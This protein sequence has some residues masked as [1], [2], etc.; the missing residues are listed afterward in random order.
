M[1]GDLSKPAALT[2][3]QRMPDGGVEEVRDTLYLQVPPQGG[4]VVYVGVRAV[5]FEGCRLDL[6]AS[7]FGADGGPLETEEKRRVELGDAGYS[8]PSDPAN[9]ANVPVCPNNGMHELLGT[10]WALVVELAQRDGRSA[11][12]T[13]PV[14]FSCDAGGPDCA[15]ECAKGYELGK[16]GRDAG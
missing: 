4:H 2:V 15:C 14:A 13:L 16:C 6:A 10:P 1:F 3:L 12:V 5:N 7:V 8:D 9:F 11:K